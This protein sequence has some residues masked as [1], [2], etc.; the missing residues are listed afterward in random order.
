[1]LRWLRRILAVIAILIALSVLVPL[2][3]IEGTC[4][5]S[6]GA[7]AAPA[8]ASDVARDRRAGLS[9][10]A[11]QHLLHLPRMVHRLFLRGFRPLPRSL[12]RKPLQLSRPYL[13][14]LAELLH[15]QP[16]GAGDRRIAR[17]SQD[18]DLR[19]RRQLLRRIRHQGTLRKHHRPRVRMDQ[20]REAHAAGRIR[21]R[22]AAGLCRV[23]LHHPLVQISVPR[24]ARWPDGDL[25]ADAEPLAQHGSATSRWARN[26]SSRSAMP[27]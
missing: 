11:E 6:S 12:Q 23:P 18:D 19:D 16:R 26:I 14:L 10:Q 2:A 5:P 8:P 25:G 27:R 24:K 13:R 15:H 20:G 21:P 22:R 7:A 1:M 3:Y 9:A 17:R 4:R